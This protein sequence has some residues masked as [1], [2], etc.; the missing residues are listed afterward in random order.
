[1]IF[2]TYQGSN[3]LGEVL[4]FA[5][6]LNFVKKSGA[7]YSYNDGKIGQGRIKAIT[8]LEEN[9]Q[10]AQELEAKVRE[11]KLGNLDDL[12]VHHDD[13]SHEEMPE[14]VEE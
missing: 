4:D 10:I 12:L 8:F 3:F 11:A 1:M 13:D 2:Y 7:W 14:E 9:P 6:D 5:V